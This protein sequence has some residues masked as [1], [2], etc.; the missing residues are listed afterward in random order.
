MNLKLK[1]AFQLLITNHKLID[2]CETKRNNH[3]MKK[4]PARYTGINNNCV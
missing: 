4:Y 3:M 2:I 1:W